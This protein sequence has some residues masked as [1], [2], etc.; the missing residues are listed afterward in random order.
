MALKS[1]KKKRICSLLLTGLMLV[2]MVPTSV[3]AEETITEP[4]TVAETVA[5]IPATDEITGA[6]EV[7]ATSET[8]APALDEISGATEGFSGNEEEILSQETDTE[9]LAGGARRSPRQIS[10]LTGLRTAYL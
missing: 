5:E 8:E 1:S 10:R 6:T 7:A 3:F 2:S 4:E 9:I